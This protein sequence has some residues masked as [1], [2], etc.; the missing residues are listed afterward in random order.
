[1][2]VF[3]VI[4]DQEQ[5]ITSR[6]VYQVE[7][8]TAAEAIAKVRSDDPP[9]FAWWGDIGDR[10]YGASDYAAAPTQDQAEAMMATVSIAAADLPADQAYYSETH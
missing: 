3:T 7:A 6:Y 1:M 4:E 5:I 10:D 2:P 9:E 8:A